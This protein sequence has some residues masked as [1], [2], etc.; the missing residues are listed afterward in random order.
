MSEKFL[1]KS[2]VPAEESQEGGVLETE[3]KSLVAQAE[4]LQKDMTGLSPEAEVK[5]AEMMA[6][7]KYSNVTKFLEV[8]VASGVVAAGAYL[9]ADVMHPFK[10]PLNMTLVTVTL[11]YAGCSALLIEAFRDKYEKYQEKIN[12]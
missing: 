4:S 11:S 10:D 12:S 6:E 7:Y 2:V 9:G 3:E 8:L 5:L 1:E